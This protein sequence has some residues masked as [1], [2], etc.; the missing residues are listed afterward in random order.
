MGSICSS[1]E[2]QDDQESDMALAA[3]R[4]STSVPPLHPNI[5]SIVQLTVAHACKVYFS[6]P[7]VKHVQCQPDGQ[8]P[9]DDGWVDVWAQLSSTTLSIWDMKEIK[10]ANKKGLEVP[11]TVISHMPDIDPIIFPRFPDLFPDPISNS[12]L[13][14]L[15][16]PPYAHSIQQD[17]WT[18]PPLGF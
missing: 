9:K 13:D 4:N 14:P 16:C 18:L 6:G 3:C 11:P 7:L 12:F 8:H 10:E 17:I 15:S 1:P 2:K 5:H